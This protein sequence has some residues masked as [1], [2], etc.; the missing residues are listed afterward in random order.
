[1]LRTKVLLGFM[2]GSFSK[3]L[4]PHNMLPSVEDQEPLKWSLHLCRPHQETSLFQVTFATD[5]SQLVKM[6]SEPEE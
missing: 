2:I 1:M 3:P 5:C 4:Y 6:V